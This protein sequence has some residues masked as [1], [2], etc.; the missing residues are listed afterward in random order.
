MKT[1]ATSCQRQADM[2]R[3]RVVLPGEHGDAIAEK[4]RRTGEIEIADAIWNQLC[5]FVDRG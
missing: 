3:K 5:E 2:A 1:D 4:A